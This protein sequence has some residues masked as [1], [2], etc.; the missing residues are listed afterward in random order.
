MRVVGLDPSTKYGGL[1]S[2]V[3]GEI[4]AVNCWKPSSDKLSEPARLL[5][6]RRWLKFKL[7]ILK[8][9]VVAIEKLAVFQNKKV[10]RALSH[11]EAVAIV[12]SAEIR[13][14]IVISIQVTTARGNVFGKGNLSKD[15][16]WVA[17]KKKFPDVDFGHKT[18]GGLDKADAAVVGLAAPK[19]IERR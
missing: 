19:F 11:F 1:A 17:I 8:P 14:T 16:A 18:T 5:E 6:Y 10:I 2:V 12:T 15:D 3:D 13:N 9:D 7:K 4:N